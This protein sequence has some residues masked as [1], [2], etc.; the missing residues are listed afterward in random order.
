MPGAMLQSFAQADPCDVLSAIKIPILLFYGD[1]DKRS[2]L[3]IAWEFYEIIPA[4]ELVIKNES[5]IC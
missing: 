1:A 2:P 4:S 5:A 3:H